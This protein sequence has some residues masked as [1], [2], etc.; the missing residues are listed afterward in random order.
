LV[1]ISIVNPVNPVNP[2]VC[3]LFLTTQDSAFNVFPQAQNRAGPS[4]RM[5]KNAALSRERRCYL[6]KR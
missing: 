4:T 3:F 1:S 5:K 6:S 2:V